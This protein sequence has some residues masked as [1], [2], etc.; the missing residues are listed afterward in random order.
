MANLTGYAF[1]LLTNAINNSVLFT[2]QFIDVIT[3]IDKVKSIS[4]REI[5]MS[6]VHIIMR[7]LAFK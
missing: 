3:Q 2:L 7:R 4:A 6:M 1:A 5:E